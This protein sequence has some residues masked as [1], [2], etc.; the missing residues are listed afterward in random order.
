MRFYMYLECNSQNINRNENIT[1]QT[2]KEK[3]NTHLHFIQ[4]IEMTK[5]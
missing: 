3:L 4:I 1:N 5:Q 2:I